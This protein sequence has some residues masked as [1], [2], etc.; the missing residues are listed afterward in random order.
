M[1]D[2]TDTELIER[3]NGGDE[4][5][6]GELVRRHQ[7]VAFRVA[8]LV[9]RSAADAEEATQDGFVKAWRALGRFRD[10]APFRPWVLHIVR[11]EARNVARSR[12]RRQAMHE[13]LGLQPTLDEPGADAGALAAAQRT[14]LLPI[15]PRV[16][17]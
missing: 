2:P 12:G 5:A 13:R 16:I 7:A 11:N 15:E 3:A 9:T 8:Y 6:Y 14:Q 1:H 17:Q 4:A 10:G